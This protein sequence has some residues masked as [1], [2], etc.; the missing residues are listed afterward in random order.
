MNF[1]VTKKETYSIVA[2][3]VEKLDT[4]NSPE[5][6]ELFIELNKDLVSQIILDLSNTKYCNSTGLSSILAGNRLCKN[7]NG[8]FIITGL[9]PNVRKMIEIAQLHR[10]FTITDT[11]QEA[12]KLMD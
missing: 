9:Q 11:L 12:E 10:V 4:L 6:K 5:L 1:T 3:E 8:Q 2:S 7:A